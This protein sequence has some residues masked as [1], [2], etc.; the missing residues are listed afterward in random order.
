MSY[1]VYHDVDLGAGKPT[2]TLM[3]VPQEMAHEASFR[4][5]GCPVR[6]ERDLLSRSLF[7]RLMDLYRTGI[8]I[9]IYYRLHYSF[10]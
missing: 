4:K 3:R 1:P 7:T 10:S 6:L 5:S 9:R 2:H 8:S